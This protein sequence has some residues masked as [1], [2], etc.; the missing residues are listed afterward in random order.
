MR[1]IS[2]I[3]LIAIL[4]SCGKDKIEPANSTSTTQSESTPET[5]VATSAEEVSGTWVADN[6]LEG[7]K[8]TKSVYQNRDSKTKVLFFTLDKNELLNSVGML[9][10]FTAHEGGYDVQIKFDESK[11]AFA[12]DE[13][14]KVN[15]ADFEES[16]ELKMNG[17]KKLEMVMSG[18]TEVYQKINSDLAA[19]LRKI[20]F[21]GN[22]TEKG[23][24]TKITFGSDGKVNFKDYTKYDV[25]YDFAD[26]TQKFDGILLSK[27]NSTDSDLYQFKING[28]T[29]EL[30]LMHENEKDRTLKPEGNKI[31]LTKE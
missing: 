4:I 18:K 27:G 8:K 12:K 17:S 3:A 23:A 30:Q 13:R 7:I 15:N 26:G 20:L 24:P 19:E 31:V 1:K 21:E 16:F 28:K 9:K 10:G 11:K 29:L 25:I 6:F 2:Q 5:P 22:Y 14:I